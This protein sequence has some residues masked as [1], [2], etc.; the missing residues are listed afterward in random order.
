M[1]VGEGAARHK[2]G[3]YRRP[4]ELGQLAQRLAGPCLQDPATG[5]NHGAL[6]S[7]YQPYRLAH[8]PGMALDGGLVPRQRGGDFLVVW[9]VPLEASLEH[10]FGDVQQDRARPARGGQ[11]KRL[12]YG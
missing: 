7:C 3:D 8:H 6:R 11:Q 1:A 12:P 2:C 9:P 4:G 5:V 10:V